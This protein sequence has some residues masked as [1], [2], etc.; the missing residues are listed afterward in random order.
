M[1][2]RFF[3]LYKNKSKCP[4]YDCCRVMLVI[5]LGASIWVGGVA[6]VFSPLQPRVLCRRPKPGKILKYSVYQ[7][8]ASFKLRNNLNLI[9]KHFL[10]LRF[11]LYHPAV[12]T[13]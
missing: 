6:T 4:F 8:T 10:L 7:I 5:L 9:L 1:H 13:L 12:F 2:V 3:P 11:G